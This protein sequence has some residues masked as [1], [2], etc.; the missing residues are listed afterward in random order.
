MTFT[1]AYQL[2]PPSPEERQEGL[3]GAGVGC[4]LSRSHLGFGKIVPF[5]G[6]P[7]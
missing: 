6:I 3:E 5:E 4:F 7:C 1:S 2:Y